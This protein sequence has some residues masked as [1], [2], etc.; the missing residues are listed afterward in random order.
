[1]TREQQILDEFAWVRRRARLLAAGRHIDA[2]DLA[3]ETMIDA[4]VR[5]RVGYRAPH[6]R[7]WLSQILRSLAIKG[8]RKRQRSLIPAH[9]VGIV[10][11]VDRADEGLVLRDLQRAFSALPPERQRAIELIAIDGL[12]VEEAAAVEG[13]HKGVIKVRLAHGRYELEQRMDGAW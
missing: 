9:G 1:M 6:I 4:V 13:V 5:S 7:A 8:Y 11:S 12:S 10:A 2:D 3:Q